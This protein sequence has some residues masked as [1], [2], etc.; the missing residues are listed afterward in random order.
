MKYKKKIK[1][2]AKNLLENPI[3]SLKKQLPKQKIG[4][5][6]KWFIIILGLM[7]AGSAILEIFV[8]NAWYLKLPASSKGEFRLDFNNV[9]C[10]NSYVNDGILY[11]DKTTDLHIKTSSYIARLKITLADKSSKLALKYMDKNESINM[12]STASPIAKKNCI[13]NTYSYPQNIYYRL[14]IDAGNIVAIKSIVVNNS[15][16]FNFSR[17]LFMISIGFLVITLIFYSKF[18]LEN[19]EIAFVIIALS[20][21]ICSSLFTPPFNVLDEKQHFVKSYQ[22]ASLD[23]SGRN[24]RKISWI[25]NIK[26]FW[27]YESFPDGHIIPYE[28]ND[29]KQEFINKFSSNEYSYYKYYRSTAGSYTPISYIPSAIGIMIG[30]FVRL[31]FIYV[32]YLGRIFSLFI[33]TFLGYLILKYIKLINL[34][35]LVFAMLLLPSMLYTV[36]GYSADSMTYIF[37]IATVV[38][39]LNMLIAENKLL[40]KRSII[41]YIIISSL[42]CLSKIAYAPLCILILSV[43]NSKFESISKAKY[44]KFISILISGLAT[45]FALKWASASS[46]NQWNIP[47]VDGKRQLF[48]ILNN[49]MFYIKIVIK[50]FFDFFETIV[51]GCSIFF[52]YSGSLDSIFK[53]LSIVG[54]IFLAICNND[55]TNKLVFNKKTKLFLLLAICFSWGAVATA[56]YLSFTPVG[57]AGINGLQGRYFA[58]LLFPSLLLLQNKSITNKFNK[59]HFNFILICIC[60]GLLILMNKLLLIKYNY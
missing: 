26:D 56:L 58:P 13:I 35:P 28:S 24:E 8:F 54:I 10:E 23:F 36:S 22:I 45:L 12:E 30:K 18:L 52:A 7:I 57:N 44:Y 43:P 60:S 14:S 48:F 16:N 42:T 25:S 46:I 47:N 27:D 19:L 49:F 6:K 9:V 3:L 34:K 5:R 1:N 37:S 15:F 29:E 17:F 50:Q 59:I 20:C 55:E 11:I 40:N 41:I 38:L 39:Y 33:Y 31:P 4:N 53:Y 2:K 51:S 32:F 21:G